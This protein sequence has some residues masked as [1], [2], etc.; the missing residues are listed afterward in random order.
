VN[1]TKQT[2]KRS[3]DQSNL[4][5][6]RI[7]RTAV[8]AFTAAHEKAK[9]KDVYGTIKTILTDV[10]APKQALEELQGFKQQVG[11]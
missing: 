10:K 11:I 9:A 5:L 8:S 6:S 1:L 7:L 2:I 4:K 3:E